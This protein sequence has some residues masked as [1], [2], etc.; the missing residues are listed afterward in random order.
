MVKLCVSLLSLTLATSLTLALPHPFYTHGLDLLERDLDEEFSGR[1]YLLDVSDDLASREPSFFSHIRDAVRDVGRVAKK[2]LHVAE[3]G[4]HVA[5]SIAE[6]PLVQAAVSVI[7][8]GAAV[9]AAEKVIE[10]VGKVENVVNKANDARRNFGKLEHLGGAL[11]RGKKVEKGLGM[12]E[13]F[14]NAIRR[15]K[16]IAPPSPHHTAGHRRHRRELEDNEELSRRDLDDE[17]LIGRE[18]Y[19]DFLVERDF[20]DDL[21]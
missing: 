13:K 17:E 3:Q 11:I 18:Y 5:E 1:E 12:A 2:G 15:V 10:T 21:D 9:V 19:D 6:N 16:Q 14:G 4:L 20:F 8:G 7:P